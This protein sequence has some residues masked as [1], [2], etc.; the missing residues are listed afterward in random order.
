MKRFLRIIPALLIL[1]LAA[2]AKPP[3][4][5]IDAAKTAVA[6]AAG[7]PD[8]VT[9]APDSLK[10]AQDALA[11]M[12]AELA[13]KHYDKVKALATEAVAAADQAEADAVTNKDR[14]KA[15]ASSLIDTV[16]KMAADTEK[17]V[18]SAK[19]IRRVRL[20]FAAIG[21]DIADAKKAIAD[22]EDE[23]KNGNFLTARDKAAAVQAT[24]ADRQKMVSDAV[25]AVTKKK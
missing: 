7:N 22:A 3:Q 17:T 23:F 19:K 5:E 18:A 4:A 10:R 8:V 21:R 9:Y 1:A 24:L 13:A 15:E 20:D 6:K 16:R 25:Q 12:Q 2:C 14:M 11:Q